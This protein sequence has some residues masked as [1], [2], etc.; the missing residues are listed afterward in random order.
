MSAENDWENDPCKEMR[1]I[2]WFVK[3]TGCWNMVPEL[4]KK[5]FIANIESCTCGTR[6]NHRLTL[7][8]LNNTYP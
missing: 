8:E 1:F 5:Q 7:L 4:T 6:C 2:K 3:V